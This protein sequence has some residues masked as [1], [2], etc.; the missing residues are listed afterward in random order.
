MT[1][2]AY[3]IGRDE[4]LLITVT[5]TDGVNKGLSNVLETEKRPYTASEIQK[6]IDE[7][8]SANCDMLDIEVY[9]FK[10]KRGMSIAD[11]FTGLTW[12]DRCEEEAEEEVRFNRVYNA[13]A[14]RPSA[15][16][17]THAQQ[18]IGARA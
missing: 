1:S 6:L 13:A 10:A 15:G 12:A 5:W 18:G 3:T 14:R 8:V 9:D 7:T 2:P 4:L 16:N 17:L 11:E